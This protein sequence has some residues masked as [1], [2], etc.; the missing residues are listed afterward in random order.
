MCNR[1]KEKAERKRGREAELPGN[2]PPRLDLRSTTDPLTIRASTMQVHLR[3]D[4]FLPNKYV[5]SWGSLF[6][7]FCIRVH[8]CM[9]SRFSHVR[10]FATV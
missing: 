7:S 5:Y 6:T 9:L 4:F 3:A 1:R 10:L 2:F 8:A